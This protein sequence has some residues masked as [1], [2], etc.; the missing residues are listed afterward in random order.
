MIK[1]VSRLPTERLIY[2]LP[3]ELDTIM[4]SIP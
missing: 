1:T 2:L 4:E 3:A